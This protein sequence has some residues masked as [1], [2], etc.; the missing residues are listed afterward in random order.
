MS[1][2]MN[3]NAVQVGC[4]VAGAAYLVGVRRMAGPHPALLRGVRRVGVVR[5]A[6][7]LL[8]LATVAVA[9]GPQVDEVADTY[10]SAHMA[11]HMAL[12]VV[13]A[14]LLAAGAAGAPFVLLLPVRRRAVVAKARHAVRTAPGARL[15]FLPLTAWLLQVAALWVWHLPVAFDAALRSAPVHY[16]EHACFLGTAWTFWWHVLQA[17]RRRVGGPAAVLYVFATMMPAAALGAVL[18]FAQVPLYTEQASKTLALGRNP[19]TDQQVAGMAM[20]V[21]PDVVYLLVT[22]ALFL[23]WLTRLGTGDDD[24][25]APRAPGEL[26]LEE[27]R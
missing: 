10:L 7:F 20:W 6:S 24:V 25:T 13:A 1:G 3:V 5:V 17:G 21:L 8:G 18:T 4:A 14:P 15:L 23:P 11:E 27:V 2:D 22:V 16:L 19:V 12:M 9:L 26:V